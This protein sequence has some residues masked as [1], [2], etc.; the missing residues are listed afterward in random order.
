MYIWVANNI[1][2]FFR[3]SQHRILLIKKNLFTLKIVTY[4]LTDNK[5]SDLM[6]AATLPPIKRHRLCDFRIFAYEI[7][8]NY[9]HL[10]KENAKNYKIRISNLKKFFFL[11]SFYDDK[12]KSIHKNYST[13]K[14]IINIR[15]SILRECP[16]TF[17]L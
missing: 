11:I 1:C 4:L 12:K 10:A 16:K 6:P 17:W 13:K 3:R 15:I 14:K 5:V 9:T 8:E 7:E 2:I